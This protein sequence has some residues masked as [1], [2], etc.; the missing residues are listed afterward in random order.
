MLPTH[1]RSCWAC[2]AQA[3]LHRHIIV[4]TGLNQRHTRALA[5]AVAWQLRQAAKELLLSSSQHYHQQQQQHGQHE[6]QLPPPPSSPAA[7]LDDKRLLPQL[8]VLG[9]AASDW[10]VLDAGRLV[11]HVLTARARRFYALEGLWAPPGVL[12][13]VAPPAAGEGEAVMHTLDTIGAPTSAAAGA[14]H[15]WPRLRQL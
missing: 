15:A 4:A 2:R 6:L 5:D 11:V 13:R 10:C 3:G 8:A 1:A 12:R 14:A 7:A 9:E